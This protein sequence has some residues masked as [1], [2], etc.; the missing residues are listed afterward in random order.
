[1]LLENLTFE[2]K[3][4][5]IINVCMFVSD[6][7]PLPRTPNNTVELVQEVQD[8]PERMV[9]SVLGPPATP[10][11]RRAR[12]E[13]KLRVKDEETLHNITVMLVMLKQQVRYTTPVTF[14]YVFSI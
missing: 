8:L 11:G 5:F 4:V 1:M 3:Y 9:V 13:Q 7:T 14:L 2:S 10:R 6:S 12:S